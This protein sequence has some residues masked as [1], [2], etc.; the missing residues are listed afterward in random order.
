MKPYKKVTLAFLGVQLSMPVDE[1]EG[2][3]VDLILDDRLAAQIDQLQGVLVLDDKR[4]NSDKAKYVAI[5]RL[6]DAILGLN[7][8][9]EL[10]MVL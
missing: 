5:E 2:L 10:K 3:L 6:A 4:G 7:E 8:S 1:V 9:I